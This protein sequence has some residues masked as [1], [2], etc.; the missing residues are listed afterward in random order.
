MWTGLACVGIAALACGLYV[1]GLSA[2]F[3]FDDQVY[4]LEHNALRSLWPPAYLSGNTRP[5]LYLTFAAN[6]AI[7]HFTPWI[8][9]LTNVCFHFA[10]GL[11][12]F[13]LLRRI[14]RLPR[15][16]RF[17][18]TALPLAFAVAALWVAHPVNTMA[19]TYVWQRGESLMALCYLFTLYAF[20]RSRTAAGRS[21]RVWAGLTVAVCA[22]GMG[23]K[24]S[25]VTA[26]LFVLV[27]DRAFF[28]G[29]W[30]AALAERWR[31][32]AGL[33]AA[34]AVLAGL[35]LASASSFHDNP[36][37]GFGAGAASPLHYLA[38]MPG[39]HLHYLRLAVVPHPLVFDY[40]WPLAAGWREVLVP[41]LPWLAGVGAVVFGLARNR[42]W[43]LPGA[44]FLL[45]LAPT[46]SL[47]PMPDPVF[48]YRLYL[49]LAGLLAGL[50]IGVGHVALV[51]TG[52]P[53]L[54]WR[55]SAAWWT[56]LVLVLVAC[57]VLTV[58]RNRLY[59]DSVAL[60]R[61][62]CRQQPQNPR[63]PQ[64]LALALLEAGKVPEAVAAARRAVV[65]APDWDRGQGTLGVALAR[66]GDLE[67]AA[68]ALQK[69]AQIAPNNPKTH[70]NL[71]GVLVQAGDLA[72]AL[73]HAK[74][75]TRLAPANDVAW[76]NYGRILAAARRDERKACEAYARALSLNPQHARAADGLGVVRLQTGRPDEAARRFRQALAI[77]PE[78]ALVHNHLGLALL[79]AG[80]SAE[81]IRSLERAVAIAPDQPGM[82]LN[83]AR[84]LAQA[85]RTEEAIGHLRR[86]QETHPD[87]APA[88]AWL[89]RLEKPEK[90]P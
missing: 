50:V 58:E 14:L 2:P 70:T 54:P 29:T 79:Q 67:G 64:V 55:A 12:L 8:F 61:L 89:E 78:N 39:V 88:R 68:A 16:A 11:V 9:R 46:S 60:W 49:P 4:L 27:L 43:A 15:L 73:A 65:L 35:L 1:P 41:G 81:A 18:D 26:P 90:T 82:R 40:R 56:G 80:R 31:L 6:Y 32:Y 74:R 19:V 83:L 7:G 17:R 53:P 22:L 10:A 57:G 42:P 3:H 87:F 30:R 48:E 20:V 47:M 59:N 34:W 76:Y 84:I 25:M 13:G 63:A 5:V 72:E 71:A 75:A 77:E 24:E 52:A 23:V 21:G 36:G 62:A 66:S 85:G 86:L 33:G 51:R 69:A 38:T 37:V 28:A 45:V 44:F